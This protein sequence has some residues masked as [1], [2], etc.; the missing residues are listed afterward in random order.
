MVQRLIG[1]GLRQTQQPDL[2]RTDFLDGKLPAL[3][4]P[5]A[6]SDRM[7]DRN[8]FS[9]T[10]YG[11]SVTVGVE[12]T[13]VMTS[14][15]S[16][17]SFHAGINRSPVPAPA[18]ARSAVRRAIESVRLCFIFVGDVAPGNTYMT[19]AAPPQIG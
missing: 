11:P 18:S 8:S 12:G 6:G 16:T 10:Q 19:R 7:S 4:V 5:V 13:H 9:S 1:P 17:V 2:R 14:A 3:A 15:A